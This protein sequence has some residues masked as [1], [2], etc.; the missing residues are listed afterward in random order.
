[1]MPEVSPGAVNHVSRDAKR[2]DDDRLL[3]VNSYEW[4]LGKTAS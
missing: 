4:A 3:R 1:M 2:L